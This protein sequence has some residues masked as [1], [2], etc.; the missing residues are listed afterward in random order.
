MGDMIIRRV[1]M[2]PCEMFLRNHLRNTRIIVIL[3][4]VRGIYGGLGD[5]L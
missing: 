3:D 4:S 2:M 5:V 1:L